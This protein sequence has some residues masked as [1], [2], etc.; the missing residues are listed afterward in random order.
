MDYSPDEWK[1]LDTG[2]TLCMKHKNRRISL[3]CSCTRRID[4]KGAQE[5]LLGSWQCSIKF[6]VVVTW[7]YTIFKIH[8]TEHL[9]SVDIIV[10]NCISEKDKWMLFIA[11]SLFQQIISSATPQASWRTER[12]SQLSRLL[13]QLDDSSILWSIHTEHLLL[14]GAFALSWLGSSLK[15]PA[16]STATSVFTSLGFWVSHFPLFSPEWGS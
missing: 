4:W 6:C 16:V 2:R 14:P 3:Q 11:L 7:V 9:T 5:K 12:D 10:L 15:S 8:G 1:K 13:Q